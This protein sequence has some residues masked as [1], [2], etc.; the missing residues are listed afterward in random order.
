MTGRR[1]ILCKLV[2]NHEFEFS[3]EKYLSSIYASLSVEHTVSDKVLVSDPIQRYR[4]PLRLY[5]A[6]THIPIVRFNDSCK[7]YNN[8][9]CQNH[10][11]LEDNSND[12]HVHEYKVLHSMDMENGVSLDKDEIQRRLDAQVGINLFVFG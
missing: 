3:V 8:D 5:D 12:N 9:D 2:P 4:P 10:D 7:D 6:Q 1:E 11:E